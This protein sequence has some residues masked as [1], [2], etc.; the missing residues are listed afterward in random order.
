MDIRLRS[1]LGEYEIRAWDNGHRLGGPGPFSDEVSTLSF[2]NEFAD[3]PIS[4]AGLRR[5][6]DY[7]ERMPFPGFSADDIEALLTNDVLA[8]LNL[9]PS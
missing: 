8:E 7:A 4:M 3:D 5:M 2:L 6:A 1:H 9:V